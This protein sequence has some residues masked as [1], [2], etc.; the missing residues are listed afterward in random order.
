MNLPAI[1][2]FGKACNLIKINRDYEFERVKKMRDRLQQQLFST[3]N[4]I[5]LNGCSEYRHPGNL[6]I[7]I[8]SISGER[9]KELLPNIMFSTTS[10]CSS[11]SSRPS[12]VL[13]A[14]HLKKD[15]INSSFRFGI[16]K[17]NTTTE[18]DYVANKIIDI[19]KK[20]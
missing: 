5:K 8:P 16:G 9:L 14:L 15:F 17:F 4:G 10:A 18:I 2:G 11:H 20:L 7:A 12:H 6:N 19:T 13:S 3:I 1:V